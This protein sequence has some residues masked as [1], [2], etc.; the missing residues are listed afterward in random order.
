MIR[1]SFNGDVCEFAA[2]GKSYIEL[3]SSVDPKL[4]NSYV[5]VK[6]GD[7]VIDLRDIPADGESVELV[8]V[9]TKK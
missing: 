4:L 3:I 6:S 1:I 5:A 9:E 7:N 8:G 2:E